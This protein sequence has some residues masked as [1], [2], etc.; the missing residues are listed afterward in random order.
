M[1]KLGTEVI[2]LA[3]GLKGQLTHMQ[4]QTDGVPFY[5]FQPKGIAKE[6]GQPLDATYISENRVK[7]GIEIPEPNMYREML[8]TDAEDT[9][10][11]FKGKIIAITL[12]MSGCVHAVIQPKGFQKNGELI[13][14]S[15]FDI[16][17]LKGPKVPVFSDKKKEEI[18]KKNPSP[19]PMG[20]MTP[21]H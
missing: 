20:R 4:V 21:F 12:H 18:K 13:K 11:G 19:A 15:D 16:L 17:R 10:S 3:T 9:A 14:A 5:L 2:D 8:M 7:G 6:T 1:L